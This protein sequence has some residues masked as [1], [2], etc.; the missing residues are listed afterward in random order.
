[1]FECGYS[2]SFL[3]ERTSFLNSKLTYVLV[4]TI[5]IIDK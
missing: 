5:I 2:Y 1:M 4:A 3:S